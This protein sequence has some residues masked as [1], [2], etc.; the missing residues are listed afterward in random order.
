MSIDAWM[1]KEAVEYGMEYYSTMRK[2]ETCMTT[3]MDLEGIMQSDR[4]G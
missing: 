4:E 2:K 1:D 3:W